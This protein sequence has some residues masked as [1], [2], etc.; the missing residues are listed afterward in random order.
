MKYAKYYTLFFPNSENSCSIS[1]CGKRHSLKL[2][3]D[4]PNVPDSLP[5]K[6][7]IN[8]DR[9]LEGSTRDLTEVFFRQL[10]GQTE[11]IRDPP[12]PLP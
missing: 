1:L 10:R 12:T 3:Y 6:G 5:S 9:R 8:G 4:A 2:F 11:E 7:R